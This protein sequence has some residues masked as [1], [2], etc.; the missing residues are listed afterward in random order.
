VA[1]R[2]TALPGGTLPIGAPLASLAF[3][4]LPDASSAFVH[5]RPQELVAATTAS[6]V[7]TNG[8]VR[9]GRIVVIGQ[10][11]LLEPLN[12]PPR[13]LVLWAA[14]GFGYRTDF[15]P[16]L[17]AAWQPWSTNAP[18]G[19]RTVLPVHET[20]SPVFYRAVRLP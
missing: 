2:V 7:L 20:L 4:T 18:V 3:D 16:A 14:P 17:D 9:P 10:E 1:I 8:L 12:L 19:P 6:E 13:E 15:T 11:P 5:L